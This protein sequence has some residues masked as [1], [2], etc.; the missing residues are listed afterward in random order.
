MM[1]KGK[2]ERETSAF[3]PSDPSS[4]FSLQFHTRWDRNDSSLRSFAPSHPLVRPQR[5]RLEPCHVT[6]DTPHL[7][8]HGKDLAPAVLQHVARPLPAS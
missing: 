5:H 1:N 3:L 2:W 7:R 6:S 4:I 8:Y